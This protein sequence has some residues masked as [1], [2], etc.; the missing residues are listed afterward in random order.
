MELRFRGAYR[1]SENVYCRESGVIETI[2]M[3]LA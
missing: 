3:V 2:G 1:V